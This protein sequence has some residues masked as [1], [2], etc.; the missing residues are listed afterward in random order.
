MH[1]YADMARNDPQLNLRLP[2][3]LKQ[4]IE[5]A[6]K[7]NNRTVTAETVARL[8]RTFAN[9]SGLSVSGTMVSSDSKIGLTTDSGTTVKID[10]NELAQSIATEVRRR[11]DKEFLTKINKKFKEDR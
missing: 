6:A 4:Q 10:V 9:A 3:A 8:Q 5:E 1:Y 2:A 11:L 7:A